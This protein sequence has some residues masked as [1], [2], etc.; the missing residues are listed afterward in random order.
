MTL[1]EF[2]DN[3]L[4]SFQQLSHAEREQTRREMYEATTRKPYRVPTREQAASNQREVSVVSTP[5]DAEFLQS[6][7]IFVSA[8]ESGLAL[9]LDERLAGPDAF[10]R[11]LTEHDCEF[12]QAVGICQPFPKEPRK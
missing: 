4:N 7:G 9:P 12:L 11:Q 3:I 5:Y 10:D 1:N 8:C 2:A 6:A